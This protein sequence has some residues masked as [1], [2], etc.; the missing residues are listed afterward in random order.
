MTGYSTTPNQHLSLNLHSFFVVQHSLR[1]VRRQLLPFLFFLLKMSSNTFK[2]H[3]IHPF[4]HNKIS[5]ILTLSCPLL[6]AKFSP[7]H[8]RA[9]FCNFTIQFV[10]ISTF[11]LIASYRSFVV[12]SPYLLAFGQQSMSSSQRQSGFA[13]SFNL[14]VNF[15]LNILRAANGRCSSRLANKLNCIFR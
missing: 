1:K 11:Q 3:L 12:L 14:S 2:F 9:I 5:T 6:S 4:A 13:L 8:T 7:L 15:F 10:F